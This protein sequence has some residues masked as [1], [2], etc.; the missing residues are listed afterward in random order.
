[1]TDVGTAAGGGAYAALAD[2]TRLRI[3]FALAD[4]YEEAWTS[5]WLTFS[6]LRERVGAEDSSRFSYHLRELR[7]EFVVKEGDRYRPRVAALRIVSAVRAG[8]YDGELAVEERETDYDCPHCGDP[9]V[10]AF[11]DH[12][13]YLGC[14]DHGAAVA[15]PL[16]P[17]AALDRPLDAVVDLALRKHAADVALLREG[18]CPY[19]W[20]HAGIS[21]PRE[22]AP[23]SYLIDDAVYATATC[24]AC[25][26]S[27][28][29]P[30][31][32]SLLGHPAVEA[33]YA[34]HGLDA[35]DAQLGPRS[36]AAASEIELSDGGAR[37]EVDLDETLTVAVDEDCRVVDYW[38]SE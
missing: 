17:R 3:L 13:L 32:E 11:R 22:S 6:E 31:A 19:C 10:A 24:D 18:A 35:V 34:E 15:Y 23:D 9:L 30:L 27:Y 26:L 1:M 20:G 14:P 16:A 37:I 33:F 28:P 12:S 5:G 4:R 25:W 8:T 38:R 29:L 2:E 36:L 21:Y 7:D